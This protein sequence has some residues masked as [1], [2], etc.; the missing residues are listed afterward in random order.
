MAK[1][2]KS[3]SLMPGLKGMGKKMK[4]AM[5]SRGMMPEKTKRVATEPRVP[6]DRGPPGGMFSRRRTGARERRL[7]DKAL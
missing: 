7:E 6:K 3:K 1:R 4:K 2:K 5:P